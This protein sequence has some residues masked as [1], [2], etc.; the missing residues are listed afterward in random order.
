MNVDLRVVLTFLGRYT[1]CKGTST[2]GLH[3]G[4]S[5]DNYLPACMKGKGLS[6]S[7]LG[8]QQTEIKLRWLCVYNDKYSIL[9]I[10]K[11]VFSAYFTVAC[12]THTFAPL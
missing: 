8:N 12:I 11:L 6:A 4:C 10:A 5:V 3:L 9:P 7:V 2:L 1:Q